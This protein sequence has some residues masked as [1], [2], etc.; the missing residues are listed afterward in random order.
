MS[1]RRKIELILDKAAAKRAEQEARKS[2][3]RGTDPKKPTQNINK[4]GSALN[5]LK[6]I[7]IKVGAA[8]AGIWGVKRVFEFGKAVFQLGADVRAVGSQFNTVFGESQS[9]MQAWIDDFRR[10]AGLTNREAQKLSASAGSM[11]QGMGASAEASAAFS[12]EVLS[13]SAD[14]ASFNNI[15]TAQAA[16]LIQSALIGNTEAARSLQISFTAADVQARALAQ[17]G[18]SSAKE[19]TQLE[20]V[21]AGLAVITERAGPQMGDLAR[22]QNDADNQ[23]KQLAASFNQLKD[24]L[25]AAVVGG[26]AGST[27]FGDIRDIFEDL[28]HWVEANSAEIGHWSSVF[29]S[30]L[31]AIGMTVAGLFNL[32]RHTFEFVAAELVRITRQAQL[33]IAHVVNAISQGVNLAIEGLNKLPGIDIDFRMAG[34]PIE[35]FEAMRNA[36]AEDTRRQLRGISAALVQVGQGWLDVGAKAMSAERAQRSAAAAAPGGAPIGG[37]GGGGGGGATVPGGVTGPALGGERFLGDVAVTVQDEL[38]A[39]AQVVDDVNPFA[40]LIEQTD[41]AATFMRD[42]FEGVGRAIVGHLIEGKAAFEFAEGLADLAAG[43]WPPNPA[44]LA[45]AG[46]H[47]VAAAAFRALGSVVSGGGGGAAVGGSAPARGAIGSSR[48]GTQE[49]P[50]PAINIW[51]DALDP[52]DARAQ[53]FVLGAQQNAEERYGT[54]V[55]VNVRPRSGN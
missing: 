20:K 23:A 5:R 40:G 2:L 3:E 31:R 4:V 30:A 6:S 53:R 21:M 55:K 34:Q 22:T 43:T 25:A 48:P 49:I 26:T 54:N 36:A 41:L 50:Q 1:I 8:M 47:F 19:L 14:L 12:Q 46:K 33:E 52:S 17:T 24:S 18:K 37:G 39:V 10:I 11:V 51:M 45:A 28:T 15:P 32:V 29:I 16:Q 44:A 35:Q 42:G 27:I 13:L 9:T 7:A 38:E